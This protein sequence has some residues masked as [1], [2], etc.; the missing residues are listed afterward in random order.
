MKTAIHPTLRFAA[1]AAAVLT[2]ASAAQAQET[3]AKPVFRNAATHEDLVEVA[4]KEAEEKA[5]K[6]M[7]DNAF[8]KPTPEEIEQAK[9]QEPTSLLAVSDVL[10]SNG[11]ATMVPKR[12]VLHLPKAHAGRI[13]MQEGARFVSY[14]EFA[15]QNRSW[16]ASTPVSRK[17]AEGNKPMAEAVIKSF[18][19][20]TRVVVATFQEGPIS[21]LPLKVPQEPTAVTK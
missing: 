10:C 14:Q 13:G 21:V 19:K 11:L 8:R 9:P 5:K 6:Q 3:T 12:S 7:H 18:E 16:L 15:E 2:G 17:Q 20:E 1:L 4:R